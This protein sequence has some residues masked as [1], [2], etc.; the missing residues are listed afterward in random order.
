MSTSQ[1]KIII[2]PAAGAGSTKRKWPGINRQLNHAG[3]SFDHEFTESPG[4]AVELARAAA[5]DGYQYIIAVGGDGTVNEVANG[6]LSSDIRSSNI[7]LSDADEQN[8]I[9]QLFYNE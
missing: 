9:K 8:G 5:D 1:V 2:N 6:M 7:G 3:L 4:H